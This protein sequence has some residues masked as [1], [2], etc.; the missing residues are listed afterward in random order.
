V[1]RFYRVSGLTQDKSPDR[2]TETSPAAGLY[3]FTVTLVLFFTV[4]AHSGHS[5]KLSSVADKVAVVSFSVVPDQPSDRQLVAVKLV[6][7]NITASELPRVPWSITRNNLL[8]DSGVKRNLG[9]GESFE[10]STTWTASPAGST[11]LFTAS[12]DPGNLM[13]EAA[14]E[15]QN[16]SVSKEVVVASRPSSQ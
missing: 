4:I 16:N 10:F 3:L 8:F 12:A 9:P 6:I 15:R 11:H 1:A 5:K 13:E 2:R 7:K 14:Q